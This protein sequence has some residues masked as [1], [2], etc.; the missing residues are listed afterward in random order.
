MPNAIASWSSAEKRCFQY[1]L[2]KLQGIVGVT[3]FPVEDVPRKLAEGQ[4]QMWS[5]EINGDSAIA[6]TQQVQAA[7]R[8]YGC[9]RMGARLFGIFERDT[10]TNSKDTGRKLAQ[11]TA[12][13]ALNALPAD[14]T[15]I[16]AVKLSWAGMPTVQ[17]DMIEKGDTGRD[18]RIWRLELPM[19]AAFGNSD[20]GG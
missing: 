6:P 2:E 7:A 9:W 19:W 12:G 8:P 11:D 16:T 10:G 20:Y 14:T 17:P 5:F 18:A 1:F 13:M 3:G 15:D 4:T